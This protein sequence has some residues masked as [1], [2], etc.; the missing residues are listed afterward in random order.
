MR[1]VKIIPDYLKTKAMGKHAVPKLPYLTKY[2]PDQYK[3][4]QMF[5]KTILEKS[6]TGSCSVPDCYQ[7]QEMCNKAV[8]N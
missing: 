6:G 3:T 7:N 2:I 5:D 4:Q 8:N 1:N